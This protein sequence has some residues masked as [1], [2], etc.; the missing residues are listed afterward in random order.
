MDGKMCAGKLSPA[1]PH[2]TNCT[3]V[4]RAGERADAASSGAEMQLRTPVPLSQTMGGLLM[5]GKAPVGPRT[6]TRSRREQSRE[7][8]QF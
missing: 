1:K 4:S 8:S 3:G 6:A 7:E 5:C 2:F